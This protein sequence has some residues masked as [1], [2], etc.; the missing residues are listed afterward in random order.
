METER[1]AYSVKEVAAALGVSKASVY[2]MTRTSR[3]ES[4]K[5]GSR[6][7]IPRRAIDRLLATQES[8]TNSDEEAWED[9]RHC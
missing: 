2:E 9:R 3:L 6:I 1:L 8:D 7:L 4:V 5:V